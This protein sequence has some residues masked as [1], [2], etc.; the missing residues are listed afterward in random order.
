MS[1]VYDNF[2]H[3]MSKD[4]ILNQRPS[5]RFQ[6]SNGSYR[7]ILQP[8]FI[9]LESNEFQNPHI[10]KKIKKLER[11]MNKVLDDSEATSTRNS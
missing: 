8:G 9:D 4:V 2:Q 7:D 1:P 5:D 6:E 10:A 3:N 11:E